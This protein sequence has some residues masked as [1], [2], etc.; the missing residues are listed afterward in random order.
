MNDWF[1]EEALENEYTE[2]ERRLKRVAFVKRLLGMIR[3]AEA[4]E[5]HGIK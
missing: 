1:T 3:T 2:E 5:K 4:R